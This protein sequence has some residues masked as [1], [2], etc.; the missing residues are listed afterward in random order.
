MMDSAI[1]QEFSLGIGLSLNSLYPLCSKAKLP[2]HPRTPE[3][4][5]LD[6]WIPSSSMNEDDSHGNEKKGLRR[7]AGI[8]SGKLGE[9]IPGRGNR[10][11]GTKT[12]KCSE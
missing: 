8:L 2:D 7:K 5:P 4:L 1:P 3:A 10:V 11:Q 6:P 9:A 12:L